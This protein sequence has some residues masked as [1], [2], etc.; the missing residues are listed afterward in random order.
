MQLKGDALR[1]YFSTCQGAIFVQSSSPLTQN[2]IDNTSTFFKGG[3]R[4]IQDDTV[5]RGL[6]TKNFFE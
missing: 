4:G 5:L 3:F 1:S 6:E 2:S